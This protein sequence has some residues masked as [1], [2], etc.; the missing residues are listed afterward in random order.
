MLSRYAANVST[1]LCVTRCTVETFVAFL[2]TYLSNSF[3]A[4]FRLLCLIPNFEISTLLKN[5]NPIFLF[6]ARSLESDRKKFRFLWRVWILNFFGVESHFR[7]Y[8]TNICHYC[9]AVI[10]TVPSIAIYAFSALC[11]PS[12]FFRSLEQS[13]SSLLV[14]Y[15]SLKFS[16]LNELTQNERHL[17]APARLQ[18]T[19][20]PSNHDDFDLPLP[21][22]AIWTRHKHGW[23]GW[24]LMLQVKWL[25]SLSVSSE[26]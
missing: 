12:S 1:R 23:L 25:L 4:T 16:L 21:C 10:R 20:L 11:P 9:S 7:I 24:K 14:V 13:S 8:R 22:L 18:Y 2:S 6:F 3:C 19:H 15:C 17:L 5:F 26:L